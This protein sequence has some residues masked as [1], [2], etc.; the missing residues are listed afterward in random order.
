M[1][2]NVFHATFD[3]K[4]LTQNKI[5]DTIKEM[6]FDQLVLVGTKDGHIYAAHSGI[7]DVVELVGLLETVK[8]NCLVEKL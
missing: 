7:E 8:I 4:E 1:N 2:D 3:K 5:M 6:A